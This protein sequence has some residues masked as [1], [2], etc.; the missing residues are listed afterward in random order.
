M[1]RFAF[2][3]AT[4]AFGAIIGC[5]SGEGPA[6][7]DATGAATGASVPAPA[8]QVGPVKNEIARI[9]V[10]GHTVVFFATT[11]TGV[12]LLEVGPIGDT[13]I[14]TDSLARNRPSAIY[15]TLA[16]PGAT[17]PSI[18]VQAETAPLSKVPS[19]G[20]PPPA[21]RSGSASGPTYYDTGEQQ[22]FAST[23]CYAGYECVQGWNWANSSSGYDQG[24]GFITFELNGQEATCSRTAEE[25]YWNGSSWQYLFSFS[26]A[27]GNWG[28][29]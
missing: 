25:D 5:G 22:W 1:R 9:A 13:R 21:M 2:A 24:R 11:V 8:A 20:A 26:L 7:A 15:A 10:R 14:V 19:G 12:G 23:F 28:W 27:P 6:T 3:V 16:G 18:L 4:I 17:V 29:A